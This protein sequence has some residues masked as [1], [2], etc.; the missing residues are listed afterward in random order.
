MRRRRIEITR[1]DMDRLQG[2]IEEILQ[3]GAKDKAHLRDLDTNEEETIALVYPGEANF[4]ENRISVLAP[5]GTAI[6][7]ARVGEVSEWKV[8]AGK[9]RLRI[10]EVFYQPEAA[11][12]F[13]L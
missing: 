8:P 9:R 7:G 10:E 1:P 5:V 4:A 11:G 3:S 12:D 2:L 6:L 13:H